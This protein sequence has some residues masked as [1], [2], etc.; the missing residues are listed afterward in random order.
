MGI[1]LILPKELGL[2]PKTNE[3]VTASIGRFGPYV[4]SK[5]DFRSVKPPLDIYEI[6][7]EQAL[8]LLNKPKPTRK[9]K[10]STA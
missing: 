3:M 2:N 8:E 6:N 4:V 5:G 7:L 9:G 10:K 1:R